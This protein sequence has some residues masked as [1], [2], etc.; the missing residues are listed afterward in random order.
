MNEALRAALAAAVLTEAERKVISRDFILAV[1]AAKELGDAAGLHSAM[2]YRLRELIPL[3]RALDL[4]D[5]ETTKGGHDAQQRT[6]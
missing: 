1:T 6:E 2:S 5:E 3:Q 4:I